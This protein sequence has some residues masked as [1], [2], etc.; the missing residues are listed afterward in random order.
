MRIAGIL[1]WL[2]LLWSWER[3]LAQVPPPPVPIPPPPLEDVY[4]FYNRSYREAV[5]ISADPGACGGCRPF[6]GMFEVSHE[7]HFGYRI[8]LSANAEHDLIPILDDTTRNQFSL[9][10]FP[11]DGPNRSGGVRCECS[12]WMFQHN[13]LNYFKIDRA[14]L[15]ER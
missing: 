3:A 4:E 15:L 14:R 10:F 6:S 8:Q 2:A 13:G 9:A 5:A 7:Y 12:G 11:S 1:L